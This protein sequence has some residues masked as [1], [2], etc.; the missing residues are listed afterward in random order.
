M[1]HILANFHPNKDKRKSLS[2]EVPKA[3]KSPKASPRLGPQKPAKLE[4]EVQ[5]P[6]LIFHGTTQNSS[7]ALLGGQLH[8]NVTDA[9]VRIES[10]TMQL[11]ARVTTKKPV[12]KD[13]ADCASKANDIFTWNFLKNPKDFN[14]QD[15]TIPFSHLLPGHLTASTSGRLGSISYSLYAIA[16]TSNNERITSTHP[17]EVKRALQ[18]PPVPRQSQRV[19]PPTNL[20]THLS[21]DSVIH[22]IGEFNCS[23]RLEGI[24]SSTEGA[25]FRWRLRRLTWRIDEHSKIISPA[26]PKHVAKVGGE[27]KGVLHQDSR[28][29]GEKDL[30]EGW[31]TDWS[32]GGSTELEFVAAIKPTSAPICDVDNPTGLSVGHKL[33]IELIVAEEVA[34]KKSPNNWSATGT[35]RVLRTQ[36]AVLVTERAGMGIS[37]DEE[38]P[39]M[40]EDVPESPPGYVAM[41]EGRWDEL[42]NVGAV[43]SP[44]ASPGAGPSRTGSGFGFILPPMERLDLGGN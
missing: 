37:W 13:C 26:C 5:S 27:N 4:I 30:K 23:F 18:P 32:D 44:L 2:I 6:P 16:I 41:D 24:T 9:S 21:H 1:D 42:R 36:H 10:L 39:P 33:C 17:L 22:P 29:I 3:K 34:P 25:L 15:H 43:G 28:S 11:Q 31:K 38:M 14:H 8:L 19:F 20:K 12:S 40:Y 7:G 35:A